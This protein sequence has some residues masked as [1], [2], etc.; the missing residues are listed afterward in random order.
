[1]SGPSTPVQTHEHVD[2]DYEPEHK[3]AELASDTD[4]MP[5]LASESSDSSSTSEDSDMSVWSPIDEESRIDLESFLDDTSTGV[6]QPG[7]PHLVDDLGIDMV[8]LHIGPDDGGQPPD[9]GG[10]ER[11]GRFLSC[12]SPAI[13][14]GDLVQFV[15]HPCGGTPYPYQEWVHYGPVG[16]SHS[17]VDAPFRRNVERQE[18]RQSESKDDRQ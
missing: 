9:D 13:R 12:N 3:Q 18:S 10:H 16:H 8:G 2:G 5:G 4:S 15:P 1:M 11:T 7:V 14:A 17:G 6:I